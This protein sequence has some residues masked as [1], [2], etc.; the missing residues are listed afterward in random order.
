MKIEIYNKKWTKK[1]V[2][3]NKNKLFVFGDNDLRRGKGGQAI[4]R[5]LDNSI[6]IRT[7]KEPDMNYSSFYTDDELDINK[8]KILSDILEIKSEAMKSNR[9]IVFS[10]GGYGTGLSDLE[11]KAPKTFNFLCDLLKLHFG[12]YNKSWYEDF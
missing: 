4:I 3:L 5:D 2:S 7:K 9:V 1:F 12:F 8:D 6:G 11:N 10:S